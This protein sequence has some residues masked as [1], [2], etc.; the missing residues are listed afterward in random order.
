MYTVREPVRH[1]H[2]GQVPIRQVGAYMKRNKWTLLCHNIGFA[3]LGVLAYAAGAWNPSFFMRC[4]GW[5]PAS[6]GIVI[7][8]VTMVSGSLGITAGGRFADRLA[9][10][11]CRDSKMRVSMYSTIASVPFGVAMYLA[12]NAAL[13]AALY[14]P[15]SF[16]GCVWIGLGAA[17]IQEMMPNAMR[18]QATAVYLSFSSLIGPG[19]GPTAV[20]LLTDYYFHND[21]SIGYSLLIVRLIGSLFSAAMLWLGLKQFKLTMDRLK[22]RAS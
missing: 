7:G 4:Y 2:R 14:V 22:E 5:S 15:L 3:T 8:I 20:A 6:S 13:A 18:G 12:P 17:A 11:G 16:L 21:A 10:R 1:G 9:D 19:V